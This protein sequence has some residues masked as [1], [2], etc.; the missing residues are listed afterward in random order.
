MK[1]DHLLLAGRKREREM[2]VVLAHGSR[3]QI[4]PIAPHDNIAGQHPDAHRRTR[5]GGY[6]V[7]NE[8][9][10]EHAM[11]LDGLIWRERSPGDRQRIREL[12]RLA[13]LHGCRQAV[14]P[15]DFRCRFG[16]PFPLAG[17]GHAGRKVKHKRAERFELV[18]E[19]KGRAVFLAHVRDA[20]AGRFM[21]VRAH[22]QIATAIGGS[23][24][25]DLDIAV[26][27]FRLDL[28]R[29]GANE[30]GTM[31]ADHLAKRADALIPVAHA[32]VFPN[33]SGVIVGGRDIAA[34]PVV[35]VGAAE[36]HVIVGDRLPHLPRKESDVLD[37]CG[38]QAVLALAQLSAD[39]RKPAAL[40][41][42]RGKRRVGLFPA[43]RV[44]ARLEFPVNIPARIEIAAIEHLPERGI[45]GAPH[46]LGPAGD[47]GTSMPSARAKPASALSWLILT[48]SGNFAESYSFSSCTR[49]TPGR[50]GAWR[51][52][53]CLA[54]I[55]QIASNQC[56]V[57]R[58][59]TG[60]SERNDPGDFR[61]LSHKGNPPLSHS[62]QM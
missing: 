40:Q 29:A 31:F 34:A 4:R 48:G 20:L 56:L 53:W 15:F 36:Q 41:F 50:P 49:I 45:G 61:A 23:P 33:G 58:R 46:L 14:W 37:L 18:A 47:E 52:I 12:L 7:I 1:H 55:G 25:G 30:F 6:F 11:R 27:G 57:Q 39:H 59:K 17:I 2:A 9:T 51:V 44:D 3:Q 10:V 60:S 5:R 24:L 32:S 8:M 62:A 26:R 13:H 43:Q 38:R 22:K 35:K 54:M 16:Q 19:R 21:V 28:H 42:G